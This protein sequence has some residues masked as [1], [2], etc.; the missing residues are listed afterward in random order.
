MRELIISDLNLFRFFPQYW[1]LIQHDQ[2]RS[3]A[4]KVRV[5]RRFLT[6]YIFP[7]C[8]PKIY[9]FEL[10]CAKQVEA[11]SQLLGKR[12]ACALHF[13]ELNKTHIDRN[14]VHL[15]FAKSLD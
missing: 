6:D 1:R 11:S 12:N 10:E 14:D 9:E 4:L 8:N 7:G 15:Q 2:D 13:R 3:F 5:E